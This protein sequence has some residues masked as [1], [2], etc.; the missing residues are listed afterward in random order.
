MYCIRLLTIT[1]RRSFGTATRH[2]REQRYL[3]IWNRLQNELNLP[4]RQGHEFTNVGCVAISTIANV[5][6]MKSF[7][8]LCVICT[9]F[10]TM[11]VN[12]M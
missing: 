1:V 6:G 10:T 7:V 8:H 3:D 12:V 2:T 5:L 4:Q 11:I 9:V